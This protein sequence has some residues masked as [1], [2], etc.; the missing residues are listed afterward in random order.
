M[1]FK[2]IEAFEELIETY[3]NMGDLPENTVQINTQNQAQSIRKEIFSGAIVFAFQWDPDLEEGNSRQLRT[4]MLDDIKKNY[5]QAAQ[6]LPIVLTHSW[7]LTKLLVQIALKKLRE[8]TH[9]IDA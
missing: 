7:M 4:K 6:I 1:L 5:S 9:G 3:S 2:F 8:F